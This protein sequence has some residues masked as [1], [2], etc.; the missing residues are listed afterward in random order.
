MEYFLEVRCCCQPRKLLGWL[1]V[2]RGARVEDCPD[3]QFVIQ[4]ATIERAR[5]PRGRHGFPLESVDR[6]DDYTRVE[7]R[8]I[9]LPIALWSDGPERV[10][11]AFKSE[12]TPIATLRQIE[13][14]VE[15]PAP[16]LHP[17]GEQPAFDLVENLEALKRR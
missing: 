17:L 3:V 15:N 10:R 12:D 9:V 5:V 4:R 16:P 1:P 14:F 6:L 8:K 2:P 11:Y 13:G 7:A